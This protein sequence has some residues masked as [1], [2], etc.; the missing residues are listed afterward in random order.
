MAQKNELSK[1]ILVAIFIAITTV[2]TIFIQIPIPS[3]SGFVNSGDGVL[4]LGAL[5]LGPLPGLIIGS[6]GSA[7]ADVFLGYAFYAPFTLIIKGLEGWLCGY[8]YHK[9]ER[10][11]LASF[12]SG[13][14][15]AGGYWIA[16]S[17]LY[18]TAT[19]TLALPFNL[20]Q[21]IVGALIAILL[22]IPIRRAIQQS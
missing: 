15:M 1:M 3:G 13:G 7:L 2:A 10:I 21:G 12:L 22:Y 16:D 8:I 20:I 6:I 5:I 9:S 4:M 11:I 14:L 19:A 17:I 18:N